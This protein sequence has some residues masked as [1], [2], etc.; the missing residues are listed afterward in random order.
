M[1]AWGPGLF[2]DDLALDVLSDYRELIEDGVEDAEATRRVLEKYAES[3]KDPD[4]GPTLWLALAFTQSKLGRLDPVAKNRALAVIDRGEGLQVWEEDPRLLAKRKAVVGK[5]KAQL[6]GPQPP[7]RRL[8]PPHRHVTDLVAGDILLF[9]VGERCALLRVARIDD[10]RLSAAP[11]VVALDFDGAEPPLM[12][13]I[14][15]LPDRPEPRRE[16]RFTRTPWATIRW[17]PMVFKRIDY[18]DAGLRRLG[19]MDGRP[20]DEDIQPQT[21]G[22]WAALA[23]ELTRFLNNG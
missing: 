7:R 21:Y 15:Q 4:E 3:I 16:I 11:I 17:R 5:V 19:R 9:R 20:G 14:N 6:T 23:E 1:G 18:R 2:S 22:W 10:H 13:R 8:R 12:E